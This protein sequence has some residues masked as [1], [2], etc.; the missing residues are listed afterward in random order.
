MM[1]LLSFSFPKN[2]SKIFNIELKKDPNVFSCIHGLRLSP[3]VLMFVIFLATIGGLFPYGPLAPQYKDVKTEACRAFWWVDWTFFSNFVFR[4]GDK[5]MA[6]KGESFAVRFIF[7]TAVT[8]ASFA[9]PSIIIGVSGTY[10]SSMLT[11]NSAKNTDYTQLV[12]MM[13]Y[14]RASPYL[15]GVWAGYLLWKNNQKKIELTYK[16][17]AIGWIAYAVLTF[18]IVFGLYPFNYVDRTNPADDISVWYS[19]LYGGFHRGIWGMCICWVIIA[20]HWGYGGQ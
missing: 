8:I 4:F 18:I 3:P 15:M 10:P 20:C 6:N 12:Y 7:L 5:M 17:V 13:P 2:M 9:I 1:I 14:C 19:V 16:Q 11:F